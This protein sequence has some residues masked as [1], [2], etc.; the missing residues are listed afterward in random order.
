MTASLALHSPKGLYPALTTDILFNDKILPK[1]PR[2]CI[3]Y[4]SIEELL[5]M[6]KI[7]C[8]MLYDV[9]HQVKELA[10]AVDEYNNEIFKINGFQGIVLI[11]NQDCS[12]ILTCTDL[13]NSNLPSIFEQLRSQNIPLYF[14]HSI[15][16]GAATFLLDQGVNFLGTK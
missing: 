3:F 6:E 4:T 8:I 11:Y 2:N 10:R 16:L 5:T 14:L 15:D 1:L 9:R 7:K 12:K 13:K